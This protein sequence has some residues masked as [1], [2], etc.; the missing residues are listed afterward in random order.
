MID[1]GDP[2][3]S[4]SCP[5][6]SFCVAGDSDGH[7]ISSE[8][9][10]GGASAWAVDFTDPEYRDEMISVSCST[11][12]FCVASDNNAYIFVSTDPA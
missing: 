5:N 7:L 4:L 2:L 3:L 12:S 10:A 11:E 9:P 8:D 6:A 1:S